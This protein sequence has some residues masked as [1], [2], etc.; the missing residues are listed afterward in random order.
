MSKTNKL[1]KNYSIAIKRL[2]EIVESIEEQELDMD[3]L[4][5]KVEEANLLIQFCS[6]KLNTVNK[7]V[8]KLL[9]EQEENA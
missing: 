6:D 4:A 5:G 9:S 3:S 8:E 1:P 2:E 7:E